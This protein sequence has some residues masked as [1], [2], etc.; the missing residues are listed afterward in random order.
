[1]PRVA[2][3]AVFVVGVP[4]LLVGYISL[5]EGALR[6][7]RGRKADA[8]R[9][10]LW[11]APG[12]FFLSVFLI[13]PTVKTFILSFFN[14]DSSRW[15]GLSNYLFVF[16]DGA[17]QT[18]LRNSGLWLVL[19]TLLS[20][21]L[22]LAMAVLTDRV[23]YE[24]VAKSIVFLPMA[25][26]FTAAS[27]IWKFMFDYKPAGAAQTGALNAVLS[28]IPGF[29]PQAWLINPPLNNVF[30]IVA[31]V[32]VWTG[33]CMVVLSAAL[34]GISSE[35]L[36]AARIDGADEWQ[37]FWRV[38]FPLLG[39][40]VAVVVTIMIVF[41]LKTFDVVYV[42]TSGNFNTQ[43]IAFSQ[44]QQLFVS[45]DAGRA[46]AISIVLLVAILPVLAF[47]L[48]RFRQQEAVR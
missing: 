6:P 43:I 36:E 7:L 15:A 4:L 39:A 12:F 40:T 3:A 17:M 48:Q 22:G 29:Q 19:F 46:S 28:L 13:Y 14:A 20:V 31:S 44:Y 8:L 25:I 45:R 32:W 26:S 2:L 1:M 35:V 38:T 23:R 47:N 10:W 18:S 16:A 33:F 34:K 11:V 30:L 5:V 21:V 37:V 24:S 9:P 42:M 41:A 27:V